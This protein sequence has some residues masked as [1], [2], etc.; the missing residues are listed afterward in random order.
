M[1]ISL[2][3]LFAV[4]SQ[5]S[6]SFAVCLSVHLAIH[7]PSIIRRT[8]SQKTLYFQITFT[9]VLIISMCVAKQILEHLHHIDPYNYFCFPFTTLFPSRPLILSLQIVMVLL[10]CLLGTAS[11]VS[12]GYLLR[13]IIKRTRSKTLQTVSK[14]KQKLEKLAARLTVLI[15]STALTWTPILCAQ[16]LILLQITILP[17]TYLWC[18]LVNFP[19]NLILDPILMIRNASA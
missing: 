15:L 19:V 10:D 14:R 12:N 17:N 13:F 1:C 16:I 2:E 9:W 11:I 6:L 18:I 5:S 7:V 4:S 8:S 3:G